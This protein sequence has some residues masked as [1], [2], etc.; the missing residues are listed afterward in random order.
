MNT[1]KS[2][3]VYPESVEQ[4]LDVMMSHVDLL[5]LVQSGEIRKEFIREE[6]GE[7]LFQKWLDGTEDVEISTEQFIDMLKMASAKTVLQSLKDK[8]LIDTVDDGEG[9][10]YVFLTNKGKL[11]VKEDKELAA[12]KKHM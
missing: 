11:L 2:K 9:N 5:E 12:V 10:D 1:I 4:Q 8:K 3:G 7:M 6:F